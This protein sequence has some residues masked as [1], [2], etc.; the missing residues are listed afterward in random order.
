MDHRLRLGGRGLNSR[1]RWVE[2]A[3]P[4]SIHA[5]AGSASQSAGIT[6][7]SHSVNELNQY[8]YHISEHCPSSMG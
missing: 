5:I 6:G 7:V 2:F 3:E 4:R 1:S 8:I